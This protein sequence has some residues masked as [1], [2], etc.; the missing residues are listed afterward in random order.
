MNGRTLGIMVGIGIVAIM[1]GIAI[2]ALVVPKGD[3]EAGDDKT[4]QQD[5][6]ILK[7]EKVA[8][9]ESTWD[10]E[11][12]T[13]INLNALVRGRII[14]IETVVEDEENQYHFLLLP[15]EGYKNTI[16]AEN[17]NV[18]RGALMIEIMNSDLDSFGMGIIERLFIGQHL[19]ITGPLV[20]DIRAGHGWNE[21]DPALV[22]TDLS[23]V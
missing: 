5:K 12:H 17:T 14:L 16:N 1:I 3:S 15:D 22:I 6:V 20:T 19:E 13:L 7:S 21:I 18:W 8:N 11:H 2:G 23:I 10:P 9:P 4:T